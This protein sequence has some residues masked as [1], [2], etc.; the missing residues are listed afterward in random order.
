[1][2]EMEFV[3]LPPISPRTRASKA[4]AGDWIGALGEADLVD[5]RH[6]VLVALGVVERKFN[7]NQPRDPGGEGGGQWV[8]TGG[9]IRDVLKLAGKIDLDDDEEL[10]GSDK[11]IGDGGAV[12]LA[13]TEQNDRRWL[14]LGIG[15]ASFGGRDDEGGPWRGGPDRTDAI[16]ADRE[17]LRDE[18]ESLEGEW[19]R[20]DAD[21]GG[22][23][24]RKAAIEARL[25]ELDDMDTGE[26]YP[27][28]YT[29]KLDQP[30]AQQLRSALDVAFAEGARREAEWN[31]HYDKIDRLEAERDKLRGI[32]RKWTAAEDAR[33][34]A[35]TAQIEALEANEPVQVGGKWGDYF[36]AEGSIP[37]EWADVHYAVF[38]DDVSSGVRVDLGATPHGSGL[39][40]DNL[41]DNR[42]R[43]YPPEARKLLRLLARYAAT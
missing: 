1:L 21:P 23:P 43:F 33:W 34:D 12:R 27:S 7:I 30:A 3:L 35:L 42:A 17:R 40:L 25:E 10:L 18:R 16:N 19:D 31:A 6:R 15:D 24:A 36:S 38:L 20:L 11:V 8:T 2:A 22:D 26:V 41:D 4:R 29:A 28:G 14:R 5:Q 39:D 37:G 9:V 32:G 13:L